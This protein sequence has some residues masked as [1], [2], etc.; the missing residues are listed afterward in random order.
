VLWITRINGSFYALQR[1]ASYRSWAEQTSD[2]FLFAVKGS[3]FI[4]LAQWLGVP[5]R[6]DPVS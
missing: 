5:D 2:G 6:E 3:R 4:T 1:P